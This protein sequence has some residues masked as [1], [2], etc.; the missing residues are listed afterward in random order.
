VINIETLINRVSIEYYN[1]ETCQFISYY[2]YGN[3]FI[4]PINN[5]HVNAKTISSLLKS[6]KHA[7]DDS[8]NDEFYEI[9]QLKEIYRCELNIKTNTGD[10]FSFS[11]YSD[12]ECTVI[13]DNKS[14]FHELC[15]KYLLS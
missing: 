14:T 8:E 2:S 6:M 5:Q 4:D 11:T 15:N 10:R 1:T 13:V 7:I 3:G 9:T 12:N